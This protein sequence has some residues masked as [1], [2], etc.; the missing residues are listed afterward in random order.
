[1]AM[2]VSRTV[3]TVLLSFIV[4]WVFVNA[5][6][7]K[8]EQFVSEWNSDI[9][10]SNKGPEPWNRHPISSSLPIDLV[11]KS[12]KPYYYEFDNAEYDIAISKTF[13]YPCK[14]SGEILKVSDWTIVNLAE[15][16]VSRS[17]AATA[18]SKALSYIDDKLNTS[19]YMQLP[20]DNPKKRPRIQIVHDV[21]VQVKQH[22]RDEFKFVLSMELV[23]YRESKFHGKHVSMSVITEYDRDKKEWMFYVVEI[24]VLG[25]VYE[26]E[27]GMFPVV[28]SYSDPVAAT[29]SGVPYEMLTKNNP[30]I[31]ND[32]VISEVVDVQNRK[33]T[34]NIAT[35]KAIDS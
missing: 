10:Y 32:G 13:K 2:N 12:N 18:Y 14:K 11:P 3:A 31:L 9:A 22:I 35:Q 15:D 27:I 26:D 16:S 7:K 29:G 25:I 28:A 8:P 21:L 33:M 4:L 20:Y 23:L 34:Q 24:N 17:G 1:M 5:S 30:I 19:E 6:S